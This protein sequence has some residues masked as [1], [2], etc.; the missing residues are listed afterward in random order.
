M[1]E[2]NRAEQPRRSAVPVALSTFIGREGDLATA[3]GLLR[4]PDVRLLTMVGPGGAGKTR[5]AYRL[6]ELVDADFPDGVVVATL[7]PVTDPRLVA[8][9]IAQSLGVHDLDERPIIERLA[10]MLG[11]R[12]M[13]IVLDNFEQ[14]IDAAPFTAELL[15]ACPA[16]KLLVTS[17]APLRVSGEHDFPVTAMTVPPASAPI[18]QLVTSDA[19]RLFVDRARAVDPAFALTGENAAPIAEICARLDGLPLAIELSAAKTRVLTPAALLARLTIRLPLLAGGP[20][21]AP[22]RL[23]TMRDTIAW[24]HDLLTPDVQALFRRLAVFMGGFTLDAAEAIAADLRLDVFDGVEA[25]ID[26][27]LVRRL[28][29]VAGEPRFGMLATIQ[30]YGLERL[31]AHGEEADVRLLHAHWCLAF[32]ESAYDDLNSARGFG[33]WLTRLDAELG[34][35]WSAIAWFD[36]HA[37]HAEKLRLLAALDWYWS[38]RPFFADVRR[39]I[40]SSLSS[41]TEIPPYVRARALYLAV[42]MTGFRGGYQEAVAY[43]EES[44]A[45]ARG[46]GDQALLGRTLLGLGAARNFI[47]DPGSTAAYVESVALLRETAQESLAAATLTELGDDLLEAGDI[48]QARLVFEEALAVHRRLE[49]FWG[50]GVTL[51]L[52]GHARRLAG[53]LSGAI[54]A[55]EESY[56]AAKSIG[57]DRVALGA[58]IGVA[59]VLSDLARLESAAELIGSVDAAREPLGLERTS[60]ARQNARVR[61]DIRK[62]LGGDS[63]EVACQK[64]KAIST[65]Q[66]IA[67]AIRLSRSLIVRHAD[68]GHRLPVR[69]QESLPFSLT[70]REHEVLTLMCQG[71]TDREIADALFVSRRTVTTHASSIFAKLGVDGRTEAAGVAIRAGLV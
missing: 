29:P 1:T 71:K 18:D 63:Y 45:I 15:A 46:L 9:S 38:S 56:A 5:P 30:E 23:R 41:G 39:A 21:E 22:A 17:R 20:R 60:H 3:A 64:G 36:V 67:S 14:V 57:V 40:E 25:L 24:S 62:A 27:S 61:S 10:Q 2:P 69:S 32:A 16:L 28:D 33:L 6:A 43:A 13:L 11:G 19:V 49:Q 58:P 51:G 37:A 12:R 54:D 31:A 34:N 55:F 47:D 68:E 59:A 42:F 44:V 53:D 66:A 7:A 8:P 4:R 50:V 48:E 70:Q 26:Q 65:D 52:L 35:F